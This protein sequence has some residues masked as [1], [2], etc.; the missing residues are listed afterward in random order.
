[1]RARHASGQPAALIVALGFAACHAPAAA[2]KHDPR[3]VSVLQAPASVSAVAPVALAPAAQTATAER[4][5]RVPSG[6]PPRLSCAAA[7][8]IVAEVRGRLPTE[9]GRV[10]P[11]AF[12]NLWVDWFD[13]HGLWSAAS[14]A[15][16]ADSARARASALLGELESGSANTPCS[17]ALIL[18][19]QAK[20][21]VDGLR[22]VFEQARADA[23]RVP[24]LRALAD[25]TEPAFEDEVLAH[26]AR[27]IAADLGR[28]FGAFAQVAPALAEAPASAALS[29]FFPEYSVTEWSEVVLA[30][31]VRAYVPAI[32]PHGQWAPLEE[33]WALFEG[34]PI[35]STEPT[36][37]SNMLR[38]PLGARIVDSPRPPLEMDDLVL[39]VDGV[40]IA[41][42]S[43]EQVEQL[44]R[45]DPPQGQSART[46]RIL[47]GTQLTP[48]ELSVGFAQDGADSGQPLRVTRI[49]YGNGSVAVIPINEVG[50]HLGDDLADVLSAVREEAEPLGVVLDLRGN[51]GG[52][53][54]GAAAAIG[55][56]LPGAP[57]FPLIHRGVVSEV[58]RAPVPDADLGWKGPVAVLV[59]GYTA[60]AAEMIA[61]ALDSYGRGPLLGAHTFGKGCV[62][63]YFD[64]RSGQGVLRLTTLLVAL[65]DGSALQQVGLE[66]EWSLGLPAAHE[67]EADLE[68]SPKGESGPDVRNHAAI[69]TIP[70]PSARGNVGPC[71]DPV[72]CRALARLGS[73]VPVRRSRAANPAASHTRRAPRPR[74]VLGDAEHSAHG[75]TQPREGRGT[76][77]R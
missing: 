25:I 6:S 65:P 1:M 10:S 40:Q 77:P 57:S 13:P 26:P 5:L 23:P 3:P 67:H 71:E 47:R 34:D 66:P 2:S 41:G 38:T 69:A 16:L 22:G 42:L 8:T 30:A 48:L 15:P 75:F 64:D 12:A 20:R 33:E 28:R 55:L 53:T 18:G 51:G 63:E 39:S 19:A 52:S 72:V 45:V 9:P 37:W 32:D 62:Q 49:R 54:D 4:P 14:D 31:A 70:W 59:D 44:A 35:D 21:W 73:G 29:R 17:S 50:D 46:V 68:G 60:S 11:S 24:L 56:F 43:V 27:R 36:L 76:S 58:M 61:G 7:R 74:P